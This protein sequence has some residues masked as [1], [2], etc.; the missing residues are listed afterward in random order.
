MNAGIRAGE[1]FSDTFGR[2]RGL[3]RRSLLRTTADDDDVSWSLS[4]DP[5]EHSGG[6]MSCMWGP[7]VRTP[8]PIASI[9]KWMA[10]FQRPEVSGGRSPCHRPP[11][12]PRETRSPLPQAQGPLGCGFRGACHGSGE[13]GN[14]TKQS[15]NELRTVAGNWTSLKSLHLYRHLGDSGLTSQPKP[16]WTVWGGPS[17]CKASRF[18]SVT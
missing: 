1:K 7:S 10:P 2:P 9:Y 13:W 5:P 6:G 14:G 4:A 15:T 12:K 16:S 18:S 17:D 3:H 11:P 8:E